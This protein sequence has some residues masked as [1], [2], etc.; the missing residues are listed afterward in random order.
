VVLL[1]GGRV[2]EG[3]GAA[4]GR[5]Y[6]VI[7]ENDQDFLKEISSL[8]EGI[9]FDRDKTMA[10]LETTPPDWINN[11]FPASNFRDLEF[12]YIAFEQDGSLTKANYPRIY[13]AEGTVDD[14]GNVTETFKRSDNKYDT[15][16][17]N[18]FT[19]IGYIQRDYSDSGT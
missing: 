7:S 13:L 15:V 19:G 2:R 8:P 1:L 17:V 10:K 6:A 9:V 18:G 4:P 16:T 3:T 5:S 11:L 14:R 12:A